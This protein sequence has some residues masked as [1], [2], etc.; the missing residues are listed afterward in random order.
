MKH[1]TNALT[2]TLLFALPAH[3]AHAA[4]KVAA[5]KA[6]TTYPSAEVT[7]LSNDT[8]TNIK[9]DIETA[10]RKY[11]YSLTPGQSYALNK[12]DQ[13]KAGL[14]QD[15]KVNGNDLTAHFKEQRKDLKRPEVHLSI[16]AADNLTD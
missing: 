8:K 5:S 11:S 4:K 13:F 2:I 15:I 7:K 6:K 12:D 9:L 1:I 10:G 14:V 3:A 16:T